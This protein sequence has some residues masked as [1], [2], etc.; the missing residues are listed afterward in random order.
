MHRKLFENN[1][2]F[3]LNFKG[4][5]VIFPNYPNIR[6]IVTKITYERKFTRPRRRGR[7]FCYTTGIQFLRPKYHVRFLNVPATRFFYEDQ[8]EYPAFDEL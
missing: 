1:N 4:D 8:L 6:G 2:L 7:R 3:S 5:Y